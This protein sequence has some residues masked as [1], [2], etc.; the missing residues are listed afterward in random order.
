MLLLG[1]GF[2]A[3]VIKIIPMNPMIIIIGKLTKYYTLVVSLLWIP[4]MGSGN[5]EIKDNIVN[6]W[7]SGVSSP[8]IC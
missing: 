7:A 5:L 6:K 1:K 2:Y 4:Y 3:Y 8:L